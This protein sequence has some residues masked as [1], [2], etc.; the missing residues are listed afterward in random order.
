MIGIISYLSNDTDIRPIRVKNCKRQLEWLHSIFPNEVPYIVAQNYTEDDKIT[1]F[2]IDYDIYENGIGSH[3]AR[4]TI[5]KKF[6]ESNDTWLLIM[7]DD[8]A[9]YDYYDANKFIQDVYY[10]KYDRISTDIIIPLQ[11]EMS[12]FKQLNVQHDVRNTY[13][14]S[15]SAATNCPNM[16]LFRHPD[17]EHEIYFDNT[18]DLLADSAIPDDN[19][20]IVE[21]I[22]QGMRVHRADF[23]IKQS[24]DRNVSVIYAKDL[25]TN[26][27]QHS[28][29]GKNLANY[30]KATYNVTS[31]SEFN[32]QYN[33]AV[34]IS[35]RRNEA[36]VIP[37]NLLPAK[38]TKATKLF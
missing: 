6:Y 10:G 18:I 25:E 20:F 12:P 16:M 37:E 2:E 32:K 15:R 9:T 13:Y 30:V 23:W 22:A 38:K 11:P 33:K 36:Y 5:L 31:V 3:N 24:M 26:H 17:K 8:V 14:L 27:A 21:C 4:N 34:P 28:N 19:K 7:D 35:I 1:D 29:L